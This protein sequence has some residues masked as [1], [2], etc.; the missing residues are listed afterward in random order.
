MENIDNVENVIENVNSSE[1]FIGK[2]INLFFSF[3]TD[4]KYYLIGLFLVILGLTY[5]FFIYNK[6]KNKNV[7]CDLINL[8]KNNN[9]VNDNTNVENITNTDNVSEKDDES[10]NENNNLNQYDLT[11]SEIENINKELDN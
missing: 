9:I 10:E 7:K 1:S 4:Y 2:W 6:P 5:Y 11:N 3:L 8:P